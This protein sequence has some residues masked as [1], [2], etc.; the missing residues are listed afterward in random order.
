MHYAWHYM[1]ARLAFEVGRAVLVSSPCEAIVELAMSLACIASVPM[2]L[3][4]FV[5]LSDLV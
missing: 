1:L 4:C 5:G 3:F 2:Y